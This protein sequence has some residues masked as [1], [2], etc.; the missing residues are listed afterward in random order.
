M[1]ERLTAFIMGL[2]GPPNHYRRIIK[3]FVG[4]A[5]IGGP[6]LLLLRLLEHGAGQCLGLS[7]CDAIF[8]YLIDH[9]AIKVL[10]S[11]FPFIAILIVLLLL[12]TLPGS[13]PGKHQDWRVWKYA[14]KLSFI[15]AG[16]VAYLIG[17]FFFGLLSGHKT[18]RLIV[19]GLVLAAVGEGLIQLW[20]KLMSVSKAFDLGRRIA[21]DHSLLGRA[22]FGLVAAGLLV[23]VS[24]SDP[25]HPAA[26]LTEFSAWVRAL[27]VSEAIDVFGRVFLN[28]GYLVCVVGTLHLLYEGAGEVLALFIFPGWFAFLDKSWWPFSI[29]TWILV[30]GFGI[31]MFRDKRK[32]QKANRTPAQVG[33]SESA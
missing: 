20:K 24:T 9:T 12:L 30:I 5:A 1:L 31:S 25:S 22:G 32:A 10:M 3:F 7:K 4:I 26:L 28:I 19:A 14:I 17:H 21:R 6:T 8:V 2:L 23:L 13:I 15:F 16:L 18:A 29:A 33:S 11:V 27:S